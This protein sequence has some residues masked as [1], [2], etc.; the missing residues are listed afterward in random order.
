MTPHRPSTIRPLPASRR[1]AARALAG[2]LALSALLLAA[3]S[4]GSHASGALATVSGGDATSAQGYRGA[5]PDKPFPKPTVA[6]TDTAGRPYD[7]RTATA[8]KVTLL[9]FG[10]T[11]CPDVCPAQM[12]D[13]AAAL[14]PL[15]PAQRAQVA[16]VLVTSDPARDTPAVLRTWLDRFDA[17]FVG[18]TGSLA[19]IDRD[20]AE[21]GVPLEP[22]QRQK[23]GS[24]TVGHGAQVIGYGRDG[25][26]H[27]LWLA[28]TSVPDYRADVLRLAAAAT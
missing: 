24:V 8:G 26:A 4:S 23:D 2:A 13:V 17:S 28:G 21:S 14:R 27:V 3:C 12:A 5:Q 6:L 18:L 11:H 7:L 19:A 20:A 25:M 15:T 22:P 16:V 10:Y 9:Y 1:T